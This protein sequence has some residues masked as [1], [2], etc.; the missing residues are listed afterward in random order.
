MRLRHT[1]MPCTILSVLTVSAEARIVAH[2]VIS[3]VG[4]LAMPNWYRALTEQMLPTRLRKE[5]GLDHGVKEVRSA[6]LSRK[7]LRRLYPIL[8]SRLRHVGPLQEAHA[9]LSGRQP[10]LT[11]QLLNRLWIGRT[12]LS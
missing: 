7:W 8:P 2:Q 6:N 1:I 5:F 12:S 4:K 11:I 10:D 3:G 9:R